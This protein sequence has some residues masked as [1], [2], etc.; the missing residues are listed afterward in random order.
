MANR[1][2]SVRIS[3]DGGTDIK[4]QL[5]QI[6]RTGQKAFK[7]LSD[8]ANGN[9]FFA[10]FNSSIDAAVSKMQT[11]GAAAAKFGRSVL[12]LGSAI[13]SV[14][15]RFGVFGGL[16]LTGVAG[17]LAGLVQSAGSARESLEKAADAVG[18]TVEAFGRLKAGAAQAGIG[19]D[20]LQQALL[21]LNGA[22]ASSSQRTDQYNRSLDDLRDAY[23]AGKMD[24]TAYSDAI[25]KL[26]RDAD[27]NGSAFRKLGVTVRDA[28]GHLRDGESVL[29]DIADAFR[30][31]PNG[32]E[33]SAL[34]LELFGSKNATL[35]SYLNKGT[36]GMKAFQTEA[37]RLAPGLDKFA[38]AAVTRAKNAF[39]QLGRT[40]NSVKDSLAAVFA[41]SVSRVVEAL[42]ES[43]VR[44]RTDLVLF[45]SDMVDKVK[46]AVDDIVALL[47]GRDADVKNTIFLQIRDGAIQFAK[48]AKNAIINVVIPALKALIGALDLVAKGF[49]AVFGTDMTGGQ[50]AMVLT[51]TKLLGLF[52]LLKAAVNVVVVGVGALITTFGAVPVAIAAVGFAIGFLLVKLATD[53]DGTTTRI[54]ALWDTLMSYL[55]E[56]A[57]DA[58][59]KGI[60]EPFANVVEVI[61]RIVSG[62]VII[63]SSL[64]NGEFVNSLAIIWQYL[65]QQAADAVQGIADAFSQG[66]SGIAGLFASV[67]GV[68]GGI[69][70]ALKQAATDAAQGIVNAFTTGVQTV[71][72]LFTGIVASVS[73]AWDA[74]KDGASDAAQWVADQFN[75]ALTSVTGYFQSWYDSIAGWFDSLIAKAKALASAVASA[76]GGGT[77]GGDGAQ[78]FAG[79][80]RVTG[81]GN[82]TSDS[83]AAW[84]S[85]GEFVMP[86]IAVDFFGLPFMESV[87]RL[88][89]PFLGMRDALTSGA[90]S[91]L[92]TAGMVPAGA[93]RFADGGLVARVAS[94]ATSSGSDQP[95]LVSLDGRTYPMRAERSV[96]DSL[97]HYAVG[98]Q[99][100][101]GGRKPLWYKG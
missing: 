85:N 76:V 6:G 47:E 24:Y 71:V 93:T 10:R 63:V 36:A 55:P 101:S 46:P 77:S 70:D 58:I 35:I 49:N 82:G 53:W 94:G 84:L 81:P 30:D 64:F 56:S 80:G 88:R 75:A 23:R 72:G 16:S 67:F 26:N 9:S 40:T 19:G 52:G 4:A 66:L 74:V 95:V 25:R 41:P 1:S 50:L 14:A 78:G 86:K 57:R 28:D 45:A 91:H 68:I 42:I 20:S 92:L 89:N 17:G 33:K 60:V 18:L 34:A 27:I 2:F 73:G 99:I 79:G 8:A 7:D 96:V 15:Q 44:T 29:N 90:F 37:A 69:W 65:K 32:A 87:R 12:E 100:R 59:N 38:A 22:M 31:L 21:K 39:E 98:R 3:L 43:I 54:R 11:A 51:I 5:E 97:N 48:D 61:R 83:I 62:L 13:A